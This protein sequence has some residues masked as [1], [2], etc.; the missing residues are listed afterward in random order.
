MAHSHLRAFVPGIVR[1]GLVPMPILRE[2]L[3]IGQLGNIGQTVVERRI[4]GRE[5][6]EVHIPDHIATPRAVE[7]SEVIRET[8]SIL[9]AQAVFLQEAASA[10]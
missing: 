5:Q 3:I 1:G 2:A 8:G 7:G 4:G 9:E 10:G 6:R